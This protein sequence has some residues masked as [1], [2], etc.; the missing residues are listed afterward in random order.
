[1]ILISIS[2]PL[3]KFLIDM[4]D[5]I[6]YG[7][8]G[9]IQAPFV[10]SGAVSLDGGQTTIGAVGLVGSGLVLGLPGLLSFMVT[11]FMAVM[12]AFLTLILRQILIILLAVIAPIALVSYVLPNTSKLGKFWW[13]AFSKALLVFPIIAGFIAI[14]R[15]F[16]VVAYNSGGEAIMLVLCV[17]SSPLSHTTHHTSLFHRRLQD[18]RWR[19]SATL[20]VWLTTAAVVPLT[21][22]RTSAEPICYQPRQDEDGRPL[23]GN[24]AM[25]RQFNRRTA[26]VAGGWR[27]AL[28]RCRGAW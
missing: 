8:R 11:G 5:L 14:G 20:A 16:A 7:I 23:Q 28:L 12:V 22:S 18:G 13:D 4:S 27:G 10:N 6:G 24:N 3:V 17:Y 26:G 1:M 25:A 21:D 19:L 2:W 9:L 15:V